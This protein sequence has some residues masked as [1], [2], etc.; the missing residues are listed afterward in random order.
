MDGAFGWVGLLLLLLGFG[1]KQSQA[2]GGGG[3]RPAPSPPALP[4]GAPPPAPWPQVVPEGLPAFPGGGW[5]YDEPPPLPVQQR[6]A[7]LVTQ[8]WSAGSGTFKIEQTAGRWI[9]FRAE[10]VHGGI[11]GVC[12][13][14]LKPAQLP[15]AKPA[16]RA[17]PKP[18]PR[19][20]PR[21]PAPPAS[22]PN[23]QWS[24]RSPGI[25]QAPAVPVSAP[26][27]PAPAAT[28]D[29][30]TGPATPSPIQLGTLRRGMGVR[31]AAPLPDVAL[32]QQKLAIDADGRFGPGTEAAVRVFQ[33]TAGLDPDGVVGPK[34][35]T[36]LFAVRA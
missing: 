28:W 25:P 36:A 7:Q 18:A 3:S 32:L 26:V 5:E 30:H 35:W 34:T 21:A 31:P 24:S 16:P 11:K 2:R 12:A 1:G 27:A 29:V 14:R 20:A 9:A 23:E 17:T 6:A 22:A 33:R 10:I 8:L 4:A 13:Y 19:A 15:A